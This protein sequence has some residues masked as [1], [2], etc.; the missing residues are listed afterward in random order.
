MKILFVWNVSSCHF[1]FEL[2]ESEGERFRLQNLFQ[3]LF[4]TKRINQLLRQLLRKD[5]V[6]F[7][8]RGYDELNDVLHGRFSAASFCKA[9]AL[10]S[11]DLARHAS[12]LSCSQLQNLCLH[13]GV[14]DVEFSRRFWWVHF[15]PL[16]I[17]EIRK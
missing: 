4:P 5:V 8:R 2:V 12:A 17:I 6:V 13:F 1:L 7:F 9:S 3:F 14:L 16:S 10:D 11:V 15:H